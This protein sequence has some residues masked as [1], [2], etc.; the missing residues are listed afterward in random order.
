[1]KKMILTTAE[2]LYS[3]DEW[4]KIYK[5]K[6]EEKRVYFLKQR[7]VGVLF[8]CIGIPTVLLYDDWSIV[9]CLAMFWIPLIISRRRILPFK[10]MDKE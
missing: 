8:L 2:P 10:R 1:M 4:E 3:Y 9:L 5:K 6:Q 7:L